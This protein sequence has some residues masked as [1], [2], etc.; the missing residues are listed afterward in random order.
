MKKSELQRDWCIRKI[1]VIGPGVV[2]MPMAAMLAYSRIKIGNNEP[3]KVIVIQRNS[4]TSG[5]KV[6]AINAGKSSIGGIEPE[7]EQIISETVEKGLLSASHDYKEL[8]DADVI[9]VC[10]QTDKKGFAPDYGPL[11]S[12]LEKVAEHLKHKPKDKVPLIIFE[13]TLAPSTMLTII[14]NFFEK[15]GLE[16]G[17]DILLGNSPNRVMPGRLV[18]RLMKS[19]KLVAGLRRKTAEMIEFL[20]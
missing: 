15:E 13:S 4:P 12:S 10:V 8:R 20:Y 9:I 5:W 18:E 11:F 2:G 6:D 19:D 7:L 16:E 1:A 3:A 14:K 17:R